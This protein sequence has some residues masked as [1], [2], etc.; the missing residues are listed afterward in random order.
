MPGDVTE[1]KVIEKPLNPAWYVALTALVLISLGACGF[2][3]FVLYGGA[4]VRDVY[5]DEL[6]RGNFAT[7][8]HVEQVEARLRGEIERTRCHCRDHRPGF[9]GIGAGAPVGAPE[10]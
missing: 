7:V 5:D 4:P 8:Q 10:K 3:V 1:V 6:P 9:P 2:C